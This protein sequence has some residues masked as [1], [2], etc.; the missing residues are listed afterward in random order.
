MGYLGIIDTVLGIGKIIANR[1][2]E[3][4]QEFAS[5]ASREPIAAAFLLERAA[6]DLE[7]AA[8]LR[9][10][11]AVGR[12]IARRFRRRAQALRYQ[13]EDLRAYAEQRGC[14]RNPLRRPGT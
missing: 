6:Y 12:R 10:D 4:A 11:N 2:R 9:R 1:L 5:W 7:A 3:Q 13:A 8:D 14:E